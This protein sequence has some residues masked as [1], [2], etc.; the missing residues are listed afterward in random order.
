[1]LSPSEATKVPKVLVTGSGAINTGQVAEFDYAG[2]QDSFYLF[3][4]FLQMVR[5]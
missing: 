1:M 2:P 3:E 4:R 5:E